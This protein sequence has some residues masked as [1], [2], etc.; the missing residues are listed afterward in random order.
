LIKRDPVEGFEFDENCPI[1][2]PVGDECQ[3]KVTAVSVCGSDINLW[4]WNDVARTIASLPFIPGHEAVGVVVKSGPE[5]THKLG[6]RVAVEN[7]FYCENCV[8]CDA[9]RG[10]ICNKMKQYGHG[11]GTT[12]GGCSELSNV[13]SKYLYPLNSSISDEQACLIEPMGVAHNILE[14]IDIVDQDILIIGCGPVGLLAIACA[15]GMGAKRI[16]AA[17]VIPEKLEFAEK[18]GADQVIDVTKADLHETMMK[19]T[20]GDGIA[21]ICEISGHAPTLAKCL[22]YLRKGGKLGLVGLPK[23]A[24]TFDDPLPDL[25]FK[26]L[27]IHSVHGRKIFHT[28]EQCEKLIESG[29]VKP[30][31]TVSHRIP[32]SDFKTAYDA[33]LSGRACK[34]I[35]NPQA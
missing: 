16:Y 7:H 9:G 18:M 14:R 33:L 25:I 15:R 21:R 12:Q 22:K 11:K 4:K 30:E 2:E 34:I 32:M 6:Q 19:A 1:D 29:R 20:N 27:E 28:W 23:S 10:D 17:D 13:S 8:M 3:I 31:M 5:A 35:M 26:S 24:V